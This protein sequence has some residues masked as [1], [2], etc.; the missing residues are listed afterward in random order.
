ME[1][2]VKHVPKYIYIIHLRMI[3][4]ALILRLTAFRHQKRMR[5]NHEQEIFSVLFFHFVVT[6]KNYH[7]SKYKWMRHRND[8][9]AIIGGNGNMCQIFNRFLRKKNIIFPCESRMN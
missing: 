8:A 6:D 3:D 5:K 4:S 2:N 9:V 1:E 7:L